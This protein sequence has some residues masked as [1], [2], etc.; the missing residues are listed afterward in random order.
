MVCAELWKRLVALEPDEVARRA[1][2]RLDGD[3]AYEVDVLNEIYRVDPRAREV[4]RTEPPAPS[5]SDFM[6]NTAIVAYLLGAEEIPPSGEWVGPR[7]LIGGRE[8]F[9]KPHEVPVQKLVERFGSD[10]GAFEEACTTLGGRS[11]QYADAAFSFLLFPRLPIA[12]LLWLEDEEFAARATMLVDRTAGRHFQLD[13]LWAGM[14][15]VRNAL[16]AA[17]GPN[18]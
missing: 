1:G 10:R 9:I 4:V 8:F 12:V 11:E 6:R 2:V 15:L 14:K 18:G 5:K 13:A 17:A 16:V 7:D 3:G